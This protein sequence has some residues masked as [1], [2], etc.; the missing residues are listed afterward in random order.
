[1]RDGTQDVIRF[2]GFTSDVSTFIDNSLFAILLSQIEGQGIVT[3]EAAAMG[4][5][6]LLTAVPGSVDLIPENARLTN[7][8]EFGNVERTAQAIEE[9]F[10]HPDDVV[11]EGTEFFQFLKASSDPNT[12]ARAYTDIYRSIVSGS[13]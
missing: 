2:C 10:T 13:T 1:M 7:G 9:W 8:L 12:V 5:A 4:R 3:L 6:S 11:R